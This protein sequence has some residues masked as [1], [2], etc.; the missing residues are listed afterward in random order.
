MD[1]RT[2]LPTFALDKVKGLGVKGELTWNMDF[3][4]TVA[5]IDGKIIGLSRRE[6]SLLEI[7]LA[8]KTQVFNKAQLL[9]QLFGYNAEPTE[10]AFAAALRRA[11]ER[12]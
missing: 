12:K 3:G 9:D 2:L 11:Q 4:G 7:F 6:L 1:L 8:R 10:N 5:K